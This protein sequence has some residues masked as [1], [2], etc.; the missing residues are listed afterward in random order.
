MKRGQ[1]V[2]TVLIDTN[3]ILDFLLTREPFY[4]AALK[5]VEKCASGELKGYIAFHSIPNLWYILRERCRKKSE[6]NGWQIC[7]LFWK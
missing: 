7:V 5:I 4:E 6:G 3:V 2:M 1:N